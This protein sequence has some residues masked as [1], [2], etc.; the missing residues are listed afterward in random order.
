MFLLLIYTDDER[1]CGSFQMQGYTDDESSE[2]DPGPSFQ[3]RNYSSDDGQDQGHEC[4]SGPEY[5]EV[6][7]RDIIGGF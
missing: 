2:C 4:T 5:W 6:D 3:T 1:D 7:E